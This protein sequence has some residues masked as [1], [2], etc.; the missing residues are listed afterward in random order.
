VAFGTAAMTASRRFPLGVQL[1]LPGSF[2]KDSEFSKTLSLAAEKGLAE[3]ELNIVEPDDVVPE[4]LMDY[5]A[6]FGLSMTRLASGAFAKARGLSL[7]SRNEESR[8]VAVSHCAGL[9]RYG[10]AF[11][12]EV[13]I[14]LLKGQPEVDPAGARERFGRSLSELAEACSP[15]PIPVLLEATNRYECS[16]ANTVEEAARLSAIYADRGMRILPD[17]FHMNI[18]ESDA[19]ETLRRHNGRYRSLHISDNNRRL[20][21]FGE[22]DFARLFR[23]LIEI[24]YAGS[25]VMEGNTFGPFAEDLAESIRYVDRLLSRS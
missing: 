17:T 3:L 12:A 24:D 2:R 14:G 6:G 23:F 11:P 9:V 21:G 15:G 1:M 7:S 10:A 22:L 20:P 4:D 13:I 8:K 16:V 5:L 19:R 18:E 25:L